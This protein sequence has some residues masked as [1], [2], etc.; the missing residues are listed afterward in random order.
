METLKLRKL[1][2]KR[3]HDE[4]DKMMWSTLE[5]FSKKKQWDIIKVHPQQSRVLKKLHDSRDS[6]NMQRGYTLNDDCKVKVQSRNRRSSMS[7]VT[8]GTC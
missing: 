7:T 1:P 2:I 3:T 4:N 8:P 5:E 6:F